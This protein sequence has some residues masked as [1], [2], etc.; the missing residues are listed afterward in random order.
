MRI[1]IDMFGVQSPSR[2]RG[3][4]R[5]TRHLVGRLLTRHPDH[6]YFLYFYEG[7]DGLDDSWPNRPAIRRVGRDCPRGSLRSSPRQLTKDF[8]DLDVLLLTCAVESFQG[9]QPP[10]RLPEG[11]PIAAVLY[12]LI[13]ALM[14]D[15][16]LED[17]DLSNSY[18]AALRTVRHYDLLLAISEASRRDALRQF[19]LAAERVATI[20]TA[21]DG[22]F[23]VPDR[24]EPMSEDARRT[25]E[26][27]GITPP[28][29]FCL[30]GTDERKNLRGLLASYDL[31]PERIRQS[32]Q[33]AVT[34]RMNE[35]EAAH[36]TGEARR[37]GGDRRVLFTNYL[38]DE[39]VRTLYQRCA[40]FVFP[41]QYEGFGLPLL[42]AMHCGATVLAGNNSAQPEVVGDAG[43]LADVDNPAEM[44]DR[45]VQLLDDRALARTLS[46]RALIQARKFS[47]DVT[48]DRTVAALRRIAG[49]PQQNERIAAVPKGKRRIAFFS[50]LLPKRSGISDYSQRL[51]A[52]LKEHYT[53]DLFHDAGYVPH[54]A[55]ASHEFACHDYRLFPRFLRALNYAGLVY[56]MGNSECHGFIYETLLKYPGVV[57][58]HDF[59]L[60]DFHNW[61]SLQPGAP[62]D[63]LEREI[64]YHAP[65]L[66]DEYRS[67]PA[68]WADEPGGIVE[69]CNRRAIPFNRR[70][71]ERAARI[72]VHDRWGADRIRDSFPDRA[73]RLRVI[74]H[75]AMVYHTPAERKLAI[76]RKLGI[77]GGDLVLGCFG[78]LHCSKYNVETIEAFAALAADHPH[79]RLFFAGRDMAEGAPQA[80]AA[81]L[82][83]ADRVR[84]FGH[85]S[86]DAFLE[87]MAI[88]DI[89]I[90]LRRPPTHGETSGALLTLLGSGVATIVTDVDT[91]CSYPDAVV[92]KTQPLG[93]GDHSLEEA[94]RQLADRPDLRR[95][96]AEAALEHVATHHSWTHVAAVYAETIEQT[97]RAAHTD[98]SWRTPA[99]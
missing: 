24:R 67:S 79:A 70:I 41:S 66:A 15:K 88:T 78:I 93:P 57:V 65:A 94:I 1:G 62:A 28:F 27:L 73:D 82:G 97:R 72:V 43:L 30:S 4:G 46:E 58:L 2:H 14:P 60:S 19:G 34:C 61:L 17:H 45:I 35:G 22:E 59:V 50:P 51:L 87:L 47:W 99:A 81:E 55:H 77:N 39:T 56:Q 86:M 64:E 52:A 90:N 48:A 9:Y 85:T 31:L 21:I 32:H 49:P 91:F 6:D 98:L 80:K 63:F 89:G 23:F 36:W 5:Y 3:I 92:R 40:A 33:L 75:G 69:A 71:I 16:Y 29:L 26:A 25:L 20:G 8:D 76:R 11:P 37:R 53:I 10:A 96:M 68:R 18:H 84:F 54:L 95:R 44:A 7:L 12:D 38:A 83:L 74:P 13:P 42:E